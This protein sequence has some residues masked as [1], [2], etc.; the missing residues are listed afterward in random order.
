MDKLIDLVLHPI[1]M[2]IIMALA[3]K[4]MTA[5]QLSETLGDVPPATLYRHLNRLADAGM[6]KLVAERRV[7]GTLEKVYTVN[8]LDAQVNPEQLAGASRQDHLRYFTAFIASLLDDFSRYVDSA[9]PINLLADGVTY[10][11][12]PAELSDEELVVLG[13]AFQAII[14]PYMENKP[15]PGRRRRILATIV[16]PDRPAARHHPIPPTRSKKT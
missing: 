7:R 12:F 1:R 6:L 15:V 10:G 2:R 9:E 5:H 8:I 16:M 3:G 4:E 14:L 11:K 13:K